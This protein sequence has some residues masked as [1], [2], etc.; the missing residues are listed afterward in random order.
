MSSRD[1]RR[2]RRWIWCV[3]GTVTLSAGML[4]GCSS[5]EDPLTAARDKY[6]VGEE[7]GTAKSHDQSSSSD[8]QLAEDSASQTAARDARS[9]N[10]PI[11][12]QPNRADA[13]QAAPPKPPVL[14]Q[15]EL[16]RI[17]VPENASPEELWAFIEE[18]TQRQPR[19]ATQQ[20]YIESLSAILQARIGAAERILVH[21]EAS[22]Q[23]R[24]KSVQV[25]LASLQDVIVQLGL[26]DAR[27]HLEQFSESLG[28]DK[29]PELA[30]L[31][32]MLTFSLKV[33]RLVEGLDED[34]KPIVESAKKIAAEEQ[35]T[36]STFQHLA[37]AAIELLNAGFHAEGRE[38][39][40]QIQANY[41]S[42]QNEKIQQQLAQLE[43]QVNFMELGIPEILT[44]FVQQEPD[45]LARL[46]QA[47]GE[48][49][50]KP[51]IGATTLE[52]AEFIGSA[53]ERRDAPEAARELYS[54]MADAYE[55]AGNAELAERARQIREWS[56]RRLN[57]VGQPAALSGMLSD[58]TPLDWDEFQHGKVVLVTFWSFNNLEYLQREIG[59]LITLLEVYKNQG[60]EILGVNI[61]SNPEV[62][63]R[64]LENQSIPWPNLMYDENAEDNLVDRFGIRSIPFNFLVDR[65]GRVAAVHVTS[66]NLPTHLTNL[67]AAQETPDNADGAQV[68]REPPRD[69]ETASDGAR[70]L[71]SALGEAVARTRETS[72]AVE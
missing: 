32:R 39:L 24:R 43:E 16:D 7:P 35:K 1:G 34:P 4:A 68:L 38:V 19:G 17:E 27:D 52:H 20:Q 45:A 25:K 31:G 59:Q 2:A 62:L 50:S 65:E 37:S 13:E 61:D 9:P 70:E 5:S 12:G 3:A 21:P 64:F 15:D 40:E 30:H 63:R 41:A 58:G 48:L 60:F 28:R 29:D 56:E 22:D 14:S 69:G 57:L 55:K 33:G 46:Q 36:E 18:V 72:A 47:A 53:M 49:L 66:Q 54:Q 71:T 10:T 26:T 51:N 23:L 67:L 44:A 11:A 6:Q 8:E 42:S